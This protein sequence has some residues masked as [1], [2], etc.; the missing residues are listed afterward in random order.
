M[1]YTVKGSFDAAHR[2]PEHPGKCKG[3]HGHSYKL[4]VRVRIPQSHIFG[5]GAPTDD[6]QDD[7]NMGVDFAELKRIVRQACELRDHTLMHNRRDPQEP[8]FSELHAV[9][10]AKTWPMAGNPTAEA[11]VDGLWTEF[12]LALRMLEQASGKQIALWSVTLWESDDCAVT[13]TVEDMGGAC[14]RC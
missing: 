6:V 1:I 12:V 7:K 5:S 9:D 8:I 10:A 2:L 4:E 3:I 14:E 11:I 13:K